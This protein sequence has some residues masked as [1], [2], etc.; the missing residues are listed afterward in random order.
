MKAYSL[1]LRQRIV[2]AVD[3]AEGTLAE[4]ADLFLVSVSCIVRLLQR[5]RDSGTL[6]PQPH[7][8]G[9]RRRLN[10]DDTARLLELLHAQPDATLTELR[11]RLG[12]P[13]SIMTIARTLQRQRI[14][15]K[16]KA[17]YAQ[18]RDTPK[19]RTQRRAFQ[20]QLAAVPTEHLV[21]VDEM[22]ATTDMTRTYGRA[23]A[24][25]R[26]RE[27][28]PGQWQ[29][30]TLI[31]GLRQA[32]VV[33]PLAFE[34]A[35]DGPAFA[36]YVQEALVPSLRPGDVVVWDNLQPHKSRTVTT[37][38]AGAGAT[39]VAAPPWSPDLI[40]IEEMFS[41]VKQ[42]LRS[43]AARSTEAV[44]ATLGTALGQVRRNDILGWF[45]DCGWCATHA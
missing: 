19:V 41:K 34:G 33:A 43:L 44:Y 4:I 20:R 1:D 16:K 37:A 38:V 3:R 9:P 35:T 17:R 29:S 11:D 6:A 31:A 2:A 14:T 15:R 13:C 10:G 8:G 45:H 40:P 21:F 42:C 23:P 24:G 32:G 7:A 26:V 27:A 5:R 12:V 39:V 25:E 18:Q 28:V 30:V 22:G 36:T